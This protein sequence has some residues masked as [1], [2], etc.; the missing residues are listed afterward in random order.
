[1]AVG[2]EAQNTLLAGYCNA[3]DATGRLSE[4]VCPPNEM[5]KLAVPEAAGVPEMV[6][7]TVPLPLAKVPA[8]K[9]AVNPVTPVE[10][11]LCVV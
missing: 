5:A 2:P 11:T 9:L 8:D 10:F 6:Y 7:V 3:R 4:Q 1:M